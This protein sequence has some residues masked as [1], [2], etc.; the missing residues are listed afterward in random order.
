MPTKSYLLVK[1]DVFKPK[2][3]Y[4]TISYKDLVSQTLNILEE[5]HDKQIDILT[6]HNTKQLQLSFG[7]S[8]WTSPRPVMY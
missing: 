3:I 4:K 2:K 8:I 7:T 1:R 5:L 6:T